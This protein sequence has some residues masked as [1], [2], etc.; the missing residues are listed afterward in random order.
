MTFTPRV[1]FDSPSSD[2]SGAPSAFDPLVAALAQ[3]V[4]DR[5]EREGTSHNV[6]AFRARQSEGASMPEPVATLRGR[7]R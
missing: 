3:L 4:R 5:W 6:V 7:P 1:V 2:P